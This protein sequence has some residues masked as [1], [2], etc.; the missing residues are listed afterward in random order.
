[1]EVC[2][3]FYYL[4]CVKCVR[5]K[6]TKQGKRKEIVVIA[7]IEFITTAKPFQ[8]SIISYTRFQDLVY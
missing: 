6:D 4:N 8:M 3:E 2:H 7:I 1:M 5:K